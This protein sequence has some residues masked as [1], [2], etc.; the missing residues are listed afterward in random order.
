MNI[1]GIIAEYNPF[2][3]GH[4]YQIQK[5]KET[6]NSDFIIVAMSGNYTQR[7]TP[8]IADKYLRAKMA[9]LNGADL[10]LELPNFF[11]SSSAELFAQAGI[12]LL[13]KTNLVTH[14]SF[15]CESPNTKLFMELAKILSVE[16]KEYQ[17]TL[18]TFLKQGFH[19]AS[20][21]ERALL[22]YLFHETT[23]AKP[24]VPDESYESYVRILSSPNN[25][26]GLEYMKALYQIHSSIVPVPIQRQQNDYN[27]DTLSGILSSATS[28]RKNIFEQKTDYPLALPF[29]VA[30]LLANYQ[31]TNDF[32]QEDDFSQMLMYKLLTQPDHDFSSYMDCS[33]ELS[34]RI[35]KNINSFL[36]FHSFC[37]QL[38]TKD[39]TFTRLQ[40]VLLHILLNQTNEDLILAKELDYIP[41]L[42]ILG[43]KKESSS[44]LS[45]LKQNAKVPII[46]KSANAKQQLSESAYT[47]FQKNI[48]ADQ[49][50]YSLLAHR[51]GKELPSELERSLIII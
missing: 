38:K 14:L 32:V 16:S 42:K 37:E 20:A 15:G 18:Q 11:S 36:S 1:T 35:T 10:V 33:K 29:N 40:R 13:E 30:D 17:L 26:L 34:N 24:S 22:Q 43:F 47:F 3:N 39:V 5:A 48:A 4:L 9:L 2:H 7:G 28:I 45:A 49:L 8:A 23:S 25:I 27:Q 51:I 50:Y 31:K 19:F 6:T 21:R 12:R 41:Y 44:I 46:S